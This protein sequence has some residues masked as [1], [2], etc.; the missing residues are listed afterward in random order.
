MK[1]R[2]VY[3]FVGFGKKQKKNSEKNAQKTHCKTRF[4]E[5]VGYI[6][7]DER[8][9]ELVKLTHT[10]LWNFTNKNYNIIS[11]SPTNTIKIYEHKSVDKYRRLQVVPR[12]IHGRTN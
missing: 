9:E 3:D 5:R 2:A 11:T 1:V 7:T 4:Y 12:W 10:K 8:Y 6:L